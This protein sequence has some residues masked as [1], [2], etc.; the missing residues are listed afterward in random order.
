MRSF[1]IR[2]S[3]QFFVRVIAK[4]EGACLHHFKTSGNLLAV[5]SLIPAGSFYPVWGELFLMGELPPRNEAHQRASCGLFG[6]PRS[7]AN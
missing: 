3:I 4:I 1:Y 6:A 7:G 5:F 2:N